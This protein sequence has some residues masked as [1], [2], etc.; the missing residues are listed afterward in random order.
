MYVFG[1]IRDGE[2]IN[3]LVSLNV[4]TF[5]WVPLFEKAYGVSPAPRYG[6]SMVVWGNYVYIFGGSN[7]SD[8]FNE[9]KD[10]FDVHMYNI[11]SNTWSCIMMDPGHIVGSNKHH[12]ITLLRSMRRWHRRNT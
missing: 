10:F 6:C 7:G 9:G 11:D 3:E 5:E 8:Y 1:G 12:M 4:E 2:P